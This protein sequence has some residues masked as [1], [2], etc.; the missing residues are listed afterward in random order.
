[1]VTTNLTVINCCIDQFTSTDV[2][3]CDG[4]SYFEQ[5]S[6]YT[7]AGTYT[8]LY[9]SI[10]GCD[11]TVTTV[12]TV[13]PVF[14]ITNSPT[15]CEG[16][17]YSE[18]TSDYT[19]AG[20]Y[21]DM[22]SS[23]NGCDSIIT[24][25]L[26]V[27]S[28]FSVTVDVEICDGESHTEGA[29]VYSVAGTYTDS[30]IS[31]L[32]CDSIVTTNLSILPIATQTNNVSICEGGSYF[33]QASEYTA[34]GT[35]TDLY[36]TVNGC[37]SIV[38]TILTIDAIISTVI[39][40]EI[41]D[42][43]SYTEGSSVYSVAGTYTDSYVSALGCDSIVTTNLSV[44][45]CCIDQFSSNDI[46][47]CDGES[48][49]EQLSEY[50]V[51]GTYTDLYTSVDGCDST[52][53][54]LLSIIPLQENTNMVSICEGNSYFEGTSE[55]LTAGT[56]TDVYT[57]V[58]GCDSTIIT[59]LSIDE[60]I[61]ITNVIEL[62]DGESHIEGSSTYGVSGIYT[63]SY[64]SAQGCDS[65]VTTDLTIHPIAQSLVTITLCEGET[66]TEG[67]NLYSTEGTYFDLYETINGCDSTVTTIIGVDETHDFTNFV[68]I[69]D[70]EVYFEGDNEYTEA[71]S[72]LD[73]YENIF[74]CDSTI[75]TIL[76]VNA[77]YDVTNTLSICDGEIYLEGIS[78]YTESGTY[79]DLYTSV[80][81]TDSTVTTILTVNPSPII[82]NIITIC[83]GES[84][85]EG[86]SI[87]NQTGIFTDIYSTTLGCDSTVVTDL[88]VVDIINTSNDIALCS[89]E[90]YTEGTSV[91]N[92]TGV[93]TD[94]YTSVLGCDSVVT[95]NLVI[96][97]ALIS[98]NFIILCAGETY[99]EG[100]STYDISGTYEDLYTGSN[101]CDSLVITELLILDTDISSTDVEI[102]A[103]SSYIEGTSVYSVTGTYE[104]I[105]Q[106]IDGCDSLVVTN[107]TVLPAIEQTNNVEIC[108][109]STF[110]EG[111]TTY[112]TA[113]TYT[114]IYQTADGC[115][116]LVITI[117]EIS[118]FVTNTVIANICE[119]ETYNEGLDMY[120]ITGVYNAMYTT[121]TG[122]DSLVITN[123]TVNSLET[124]VNSI[125]ICDGDIHTEGSSTYSDSGT[126][127]D[128]YQ[129]VLGCDSTV[130][131]NLTV[132]EISTTTNSVSICE[133]ETYYEG[134]AG[135]TATGLYTDVYFSVQG[136][137]SVILTNLTVYPLE[138]TTNSIN[139]CAGETYIEGSSSY[140]AT[141]VYTDIYSSVFG[142]DSTVTTLLTVNQ[143]TSTDLSMIVCEGAPLPAL[144]IYF[145]AQNNRFIDSLS[146]SNGCDSLVFTYLEYINPSV[147]LPQSI[148]ICEGQSFIASLDGLAADFSIL[149]STGATS[150]TESFSEEGS[151]WVEV[152]S[153]NCSASDSLQILVH[154]IPY[155]P[156]TELDLCLGSTRT[157][158]L[159]EENGNVTWSDGTEGDEIIISEQGIYTASVINACGAY[160]YEYDLTLTDCSCRIFIPNAFTA[161][162]DNL[163][164]VFSVIHDCDFV[165][166]ELLIFNRWGEVIFQTTDPNAPWVGDDENGNHYVP[167]GVYT[168]LLKYSSK[169]IENRV[170]ADKIYGSVTVVR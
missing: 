118:D 46:S 107:L 53:T 158:N 12:L 143:N 162:S 2:S 48:Y 123:L 38:T 152:S 139:I 75:T 54:T 37:D 160:I 29:S 147:L 65:I 15:I 138:N 109:G 3:I 114:E 10:D 52:V 125:T 106:D 153:E 64:I 77:T 137:D 101:G 117:L 131:T 88:T 32:G 150:E 113:G 126:Y 20:T 129:T 167:E 128:I 67:G 103:G 59:V 6:E 86:S 165:E 13:N 50:T 154:E 27:D 23:V 141:G 151:Y 119:G 41:C 7:A 35:Y 96:N 135:Y 111:T 115:D 87:Y 25:I 104:D 47:I 17:T 159:P 26:T 69:T 30:Y 57:S 70:G 120:T 80:L 18:G 66:Y 89:G 97:E 121:S 40:A 95:T 169:D 144:G 58:N 33:E 133:G 132:L 72:Y 78:E 90:S 157:I 31:V 44:I 110:T 161:N 74:V 24:T 51:A 94:L 5:L 148:T 140:S 85:T 43:D 99:N 127:T 81:G 92:E 116:S 76:T 45:N 156:E 68:T 8:D 1:M 166:Y 9:T 42:G 4:D 149:W 28:Q 56:Y 102:C 105:Y 14:A 100:T 98:P 93:Y 134:T 91:Y 82:T 36:Q 108:V 164:E 34:A 84:Y 112:D 155:V 146:T 83:D 11:S 168:Y 63:D 170:A 71:G 79:T 142:C 16:G 145:D 60:S 49:F 22:Y 136:C 21:T 55:Y 163:N 62:C 39:D 73:V 124:T 61:N 19:S 122:C 130:I